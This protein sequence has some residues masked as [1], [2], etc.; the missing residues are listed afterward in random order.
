[1]PGVFSLGVSYLLLGWVFVTPVVCWQLLVREIV[2]HH[3]RRGMDGRNSYLE[4]GQIV[5]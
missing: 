4:G 5:C 3:A 1:M 2:S